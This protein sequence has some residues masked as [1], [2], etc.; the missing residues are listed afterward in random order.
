MTRSRFDWY[1]QL[2]AQLGRQSACVLLDELQVLALTEP[3]ALRE[4]ERFVDRGIM[5]AERCV[6]VV[7]PDRRQR[8]D[9]RKSRSCI[10]KNDG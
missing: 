10:H 9:R 5:C 8:S 6:V 7:K 3:A 2:S 4:M 1:R